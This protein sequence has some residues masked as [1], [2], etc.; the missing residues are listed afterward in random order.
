MCFRAAPHPI[1]SLQSD[2]SATGRHMADILYIRYLDTIDHDI[3]IMIKLPI[4]KDVVRLDIWN[5]FSIVLH[6]RFS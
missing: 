5:G 4:D 6:A 3:L 2:N 1:A